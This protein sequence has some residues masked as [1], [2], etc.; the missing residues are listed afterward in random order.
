MFLRTFP[1]GVIALACL[2]LGSRIARGEVTLPWYFL[3]YAAMLWLVP[4]GIYTLLGRFQPGL[5]RERL[6]PP[7]DRDRTTRLASM[8]L[9]LVVL[10]LAGYELGS[11]HHS[12]SPVGVHGLGF[13]LCH[14]G[15]ALTGWTL[16]SN[17]YASSAVRIQSERQQHVVSTGPYALVRHPMYLG[18]LAFA[19]GTPLALGS[20]WAWLPTLVVIVLFAR[21]TAAEDAMLK[22]ELP[23]YQTYASRV[24]WK[25]VPLL[26]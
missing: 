14:A 13:L 6:K 16:L 18:V 7:S 26:F 1:L 20:A 4:G 10:G 21:R 17:P 19:C 2:A 24:R 12:S 9:V 25:V 11:T 22:A 8:A 23:G 5:L 3:S 15:F